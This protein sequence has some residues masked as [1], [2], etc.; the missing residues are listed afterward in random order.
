MATW[1]HGEACW[2]PSGAPGSG[3]GSRWRAQLIPKGGGTQPTRPMP[4]GVWRYLD[5]GA[6]FPARFPVHDDSFCNVFSFVAGS[7]TMTCSQNPGLGY[8]PGTELSINDCG[9]RAPFQ[10]GQGWHRFI[11]KLFLEAAPNGRL[12]MWHKPPGASSFT[13]VINDCR[14]ETWNADFANTEEVGGSHP[15]QEYY[16]GD[17]GDVSA[18]GTVDPWID[19][20]GAIWSLR[21]EIDPTG[22]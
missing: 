21:H 5:W 16:H 18:S 10:R 19:H 12:T 4:R 6:R 3:T 9:W 1:Y 15:A 2:G 7:A 8:A 20:L 13:K 22:P 14:T 11:V 17:K